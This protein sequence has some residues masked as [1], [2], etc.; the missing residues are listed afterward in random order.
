MMSIL[1]SPPLQADVKKTNE[2]CDDNNEG[3]DEEEAK[4]HLA[5]TTF[6]L[7]IDLASNHRANVDI[8]T[9]SRLLLEGPEENE[10]QND[11]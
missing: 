8:S 7:D 5:S 1:I 6:Q 4:M 2:G 9:S 11:D 3:G 10:K